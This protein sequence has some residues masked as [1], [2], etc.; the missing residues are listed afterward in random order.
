MGHRRGRLN[1]V[2][3]DD[4]LVDLGSLDIAE[5]RLSLNLF[6]PEVLRISQQHRLTA[7]DAAY[8]ELALRRRLPLATL[9]K[10]LASAARAEAVP[11]LL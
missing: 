1:A 9:D 11:L 10:D 4:R 8:L 7:Y 5:D 2:E 6:L 3:M